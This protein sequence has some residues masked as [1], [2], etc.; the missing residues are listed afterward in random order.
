MS[1]RERGEP[2]GDGAPVTAPAP[3]LL[4]ALRVTLAVLPEVRERG[5]GHAGRPDTWR[6]RRSL[7]EPADG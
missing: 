6:K 7:S 5:R 4:G 1:P 3:R 2:G